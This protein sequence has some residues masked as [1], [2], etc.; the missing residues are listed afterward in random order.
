MVVQSPVGVVK[1]VSSIVTI[2]VAIKTF[3]LTNIFYVYCNANSGLRNS[4]KVK[5]A[6]PWCVGDVRQRSTLLSGH[7]V[8]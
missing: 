8:L 2:C 5:L 7:V 6:F 1:T 3:T 4:F